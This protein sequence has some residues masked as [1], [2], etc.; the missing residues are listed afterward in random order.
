MANKKLNATITIGGALSASLAGAFNSVKKNVGE[1]GSAI[2]RLESE[3]RLLANGIRTFG[4]MGKNVDGLRAKY[5]A[6]TT[7]VERLRTAQVRLGKVQ[8]A[9]EKNL[10]KR[11]D[12][13]GQMLDTV[14]LGAVVAAPVVEAIKF[15]SSMADVN[16]V[17]DFDTVEQ[18]KAM[19]DEVRKMST[20]L[21]MAA[22]DIAQIVAAGGQSG[23]AREELTK[24]AES[25]VKV[26]VAFN[27]SAEEAGQMMAEMRSAFR[28]NQDQVNVLADKMNL[29]ANTT[30]ASEVRIANVVRRVGPLG[31]VAGTASGEIAAL[32]ATLISMGVQEE[33]AAT[34][35]QNLMLALVAGESATKKQQEAFAALGMESVAISKG[36]QSDAKG[37]IISIMSNV[38]KLDDYK[39]ASVLQAIFGKE[40]IKSI[41]P[42][43]NNIDALAKNFE[44]VAD[45]TKYAGAVEKE[46]QARAAT[47]ANNLQLFRNRIASVGIVIGSVLLPALND[48]LSAIGPIVTKFGDFAAANPTLTKAIIGTAFALTSMKVATLAVGYGFTFI[49]GAVLAGAGM[50]AKMQAGAVLAGNALPSVAVGIRAVGAAFTANPIGLLVA[51]IATAGFLIYKYWDGIPAFMSG[52]FKGI[53]AGLD[54]LVQR[55]SALGDALSPLQPV[56]NAVGGAV[57]VVWQWFTDL[58]KP[59]EFTEDKLNKAGKAGQTFGEFMGGAFNLVL[60]PMH[61]FIEGVTWIANNIGGVLDKAIAFKNAIGGGIDSAVLKTGDLW[62]QTKS[63]F[64]GG[65]EKPA[66]AGEPLSKDQKPIVQSGAFARSMAP[67][68]PGLPGNIKLPTIPPMAGAGGASSKYEDKSTTTIQITQ[69][70]GE[71]GRAL[72]RRVVEEQERARKVRER[73]AMHDGTVTQ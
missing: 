68:V 62:G 28:M 57:S 30:A 16:K 41:A 13:R 59:V 38:K 70:P 7:Q 47:T 72:A 17:V 46:Y 4:E 26:G 33:I 65:D 66:T 43:L 56:F 9:Q 20:V 39:Q 73:G 12:Y 35:I 24:F 60:L 36:M 54:P 2:R 52:L 11:A 1:V 40:S 15:E 29:L 3:Q 64:G 44:K 71:D 18:F 31:E 61:A 14:A 34:G 32:G 58:L 53:R 25:A 63:F 23:F 8:A 67:A 21:P 19:G 49:R 5:A 50:F 45:A 27:M 51:G 69:Q 37:T 22:S 10:S 6:V 55:F 42:L 48:I